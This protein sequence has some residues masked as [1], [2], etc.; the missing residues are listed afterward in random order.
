MAEFVCR[1][2]DA[3]GRVFSHVEPASSREEARQKLADRGMFVY[4]VESRGRRLGDLVRRRGE[5]QIAGS[6]FLLFNQQFTT[7]IKAGLPSLETLD[8]FATRASV[9]KLRP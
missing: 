9:P 8:L 6:D 7:L 1:V 3:E 2:A 5:R 4:S